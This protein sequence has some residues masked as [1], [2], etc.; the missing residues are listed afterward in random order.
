MFF[1]IDREL[2]SKGDIDTVNINK[3]WTVC[4]EQHT[5]YQ[6]LFDDIDA[7]EKSTWYQNLSEI[8]KKLWEES[9]SNSVQMGDK[10]DKVKVFIGNTHTAFEAYHYLTSPLKIVLENSR[11]DAH[12][13]KAIFKAFRQEAKTI[14]K[15]LDNRWVQFS[16]GGGSSIIQVIE[17]EMESF[18]S[19]LFE[20]DN[21]EYL[22][23]FVLLDSDKSYPNEPLK[24][25]TENLVAFL[26]EKQILFHILE[27]REMENYIPDAAFV[28]VLENRPFIDAYL[29]LTADQK[30]YFDLEKGLSQRNFD[31]LSP[32]LKL[33]FG[34]VCDEDKIIFRHFDLKRFTNSGLEDFK[35]EC[36][37]LFNSDHVTKAALVART[38]NQ[39]NPNELKDIIQKI[40]ELL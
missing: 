33:L 15:H 2:F 20:K 17:T 10:Y 37:K 9:V 39:T 3:I 23:C 38:K 27:K 6:N 13:L 24:Q 36:P 22:R 29:R 12:F 31:N 7:T 1:T 32:E 11:N 34:T 30:D 14:S 21:H 19:E 28:D 5:F 8:D 35:S 4:T 40:R 16:M 18:S 25:G 26:R